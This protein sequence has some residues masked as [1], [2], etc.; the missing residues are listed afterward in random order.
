[1]ANY[2]TD[3][4][5]P[6]AAFP[7]TSTVKFS[8]TGSSTVAF[9][10]ATPISHVGEVAAFIDG[11]AYRMRSGRLVKAALPRALNANPKHVLRLFAELE[12]D[13]YITMIKDK[14]YTVVKR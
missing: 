9:N 2:P 3:A 12:Q 11:V 1:M 8:N 5:A 10:L 7:V 4:I 6:T 14:G 13:G